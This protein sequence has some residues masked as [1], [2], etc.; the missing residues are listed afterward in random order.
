MDGWLAISVVSF[1]AAGLFFCVYQWAALRREQTVASRLASASDDSFADVPASTLLGGLT[2]PLAEVPMSEEQKATLRRELME[3]GLYR[4]TALME[5]T[6]LRVALVGVPLIGA[7]ALAVLVDRIWIPRVLAAGLILAAL[8]FSIPRV[9]LHF[10][11]RRRSQQIERGL[12]VA[13]DLLA[14]SLSGGLHVYPALARVARELRHSYPVLAEELMIVQHQAGL[15]NLDHALAGFAARTNVQEVRNL[16]LILTQSERLGTDITAALLEFSTN[17]RT[18]LRQRAEGYANRAN[19]W[20]LFPTILCLWLPAVVILFAPVLFE[21][22]R[23]MQ[24]AGETMRKSFEQLKKLQRL[25][26]RSR[27]NNE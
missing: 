11:R 21:A 15:S 23:G 25:E 12:P 18:T 10:M 3:A 1:L 2:E 7:A 26:P 22:R 4:P 8:G 14:L 17:F 5:Y 27:N 20:M 9:I 13:V 19:F 6:A 24:E 16:A